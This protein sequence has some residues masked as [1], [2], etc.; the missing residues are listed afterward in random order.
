MK[1]NWLDWPMLAM[2]RPGTF[3][4]A[5]TSAG[6]P[7]SNVSDIVALS[8]ALIVLRS[9]DAVNVPASAAGAKP[10]ITTQIKSK[11]QI[12]PPWRGSGNRKSKIENRKCIFTNL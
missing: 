5:G 10:G 6:N 9:N 3:G 8:F 7:P 11:R 12:Q 1:L 2:E 4:A